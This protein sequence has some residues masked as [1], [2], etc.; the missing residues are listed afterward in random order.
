MAKP[1]WSGQSTREYGM[2]KGKKMKPQI[3][4]AEEHYNTMIYT[5]DC[6][7]G[8]YPAPHKEYPL[9]PTGLLHAADNVLIY[10]MEDYQLRSAER[11]REIAITLINKEWHPYKFIQITNLKEK[12]ST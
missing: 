1:I 9:N 7:L 11:C 8:L 10:S 3:S 2:S 4:I 6:V 12:R 5:H